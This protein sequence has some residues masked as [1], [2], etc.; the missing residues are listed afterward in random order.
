MSTTQNTGLTTIFVIRHAEKPGP[1]GGTVYNGVNPTA[2]VCGL[3]G[4]E[5]LTT[6]GWQRAGGLVTL[7]G[8]K[9]FGPRKDLATPDHIYAADPAD[10]KS[11]KAPSQRPYETILGLAAV[12]GT[13]GTP[14]TI[15]TEFAKKDYSKM[16]TDVL[17]RS[18]VVLVCWQHEDIPLQAEGDVAGI[19]QEILTQTGTTAQFPIP[20]TWPKDANG[21]ARYDL[22]FA[23]TRDTTS[24][25]ISGFQ[26]LPQ[27]L[28]AGDA[29]V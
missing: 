22:I 23:F 28:V 25:Q 26:L 5:D 14:K 11:G 6:Q 4:A 7:F 8:P 10:K 2:T 1:Y 16:V 19:S 21:Q 12:L 15:H 17:T 13:G 20:A 9:P 29:A 27:Y 24:G 18:G 3:D